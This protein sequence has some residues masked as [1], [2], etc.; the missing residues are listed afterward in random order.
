MGKPEKEA[1]SVTLKAP[2]RLAKWAAASG[3]DAEIVLTRNG[4]T[5]ED[6][7]DPGADPG[8]IDDPIDGKELELLRGLLNAYD[9]A[10]KRDDE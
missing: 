8:P 7:K 9:K 4:E 6:A 10:G 2:K 1:A 3:F 5:S